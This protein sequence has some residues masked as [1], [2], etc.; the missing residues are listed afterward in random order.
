MSTQ[1]ILEKYISICNIKLIKSNRILAFMQKYGI[2]ENYIFEN[3]CIGYSN[4]ELLKIIAENIMYY[5]K[6]R[7]I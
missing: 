5:F 3:F 2:Y 1:E 6:I 4:G 7:R